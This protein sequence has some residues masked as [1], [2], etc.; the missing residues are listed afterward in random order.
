MVEFDTIA[1]NGKHANGKGARSST[2]LTNGRKRPKNAPSLTIEVG[3]E[4]P[5]HLAPPDL[6]PEELDAIREFTEGVEGPITFS[7]VALPHWAPENRYCLYMLVGELKQRCRLKL[8]GVVYADAFDAALAS[9]VGSDRLDQHDLA[10]KAA[11][12]TAAFFHGAVP[13]AAAAKINERLTVLKS[14]KINSQRLCKQIRDMA[15]AAQR[16]SSTSDSLSAAQ[17]FMAQLEEQLPA[18]DGPVLRFFNQD[19][20]LWQGHSWQSVADACF[21]AQVMRFLQTLDVPQLTERFARDVVAHLRART[22]IDCWD[23]SM[24]FLILDESLWKLDY[25]PWIVFPNGVIDL[26]HVTAADAQGANLFRIH[27]DFFNEI[28]MPFEFDATAKCQLW[29]ETLDAILPVTADDDHRQ[30]VLQEFF[31]YGLIHTCRFQK[32]LVLVGDGGNGKS[33]ITETWQALLGDANYSSIPLQSLGD[34]FRLWSLKGKLANFSGELPYLG[35]VN[36]GIIKRLVSGEPIDVNRKHKDPTKLRSFAKLVVNTNE[37]PQIRDATP[38]TWDRLIAMPFDVRIRG[39]LD[40]DTE[41]PRKL[42]E[43]LPGIFN[44]ALRGLKRLLA[45]G[46]FTSCGR[47]QALVNRHRTDSDSVLS[48]LAECCRKD[49]EFQ[50]Y[51]QPLYQVYRLW[52]TST[53]RKPVASNEFGERVIRAGFQK[54]RGPVTKQGRRP[55]HAGLRLSEEGTDYLNRLDIELK[56]GL[57][58]ACV[59]LKA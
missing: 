53:G 51:S 44:W 52:A 20:Y 24:P 4:T 40:E 35:N 33:T 13:E 43:E 37:L 57:V 11:I 15:T 54:K 45:Q 1:G 28:V 17:A 50:T 34:E 30:M 47:C 31:G 26:D 38:A 42:L 18:C 5:R 41:R 14:P 56:G 36:E 21:E 16:A 39:T 48:F 3:G 19:F 7:I 46:H 32:F 49:A 27:S 25:P 6:G 23:A 29:L 59:R 10:L 22:L 9:L 12:E 8:N 58:P 2:P 55:T